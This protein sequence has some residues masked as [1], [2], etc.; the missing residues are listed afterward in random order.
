MSSR[1]AVK[2]KLH[3]SN[4]QN[5]YKLKLSELTGDAVSKSKQADSITEL[6][7]K[8]LSMYAKQIA[9]GNITQSLIL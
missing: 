7:N 2:G 8:L 4:Q 1:L 6:N 3:R 5:K 9:L